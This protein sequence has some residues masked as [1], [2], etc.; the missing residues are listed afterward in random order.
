MTVDEQRDSTATYN[1]MTLKEMKTQFPEPT[2]SQPIQVSINS[3]FLRI[4]IYLNLPYPLKEYRKRSERKTYFFFCCQSVLFFPSSLETILIAFREN[5]G[6]LLTY[7]C[8]W[9]L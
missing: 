5:H 4:L 2:S 3:I 6:G 8:P 9:S 1:K 7:A